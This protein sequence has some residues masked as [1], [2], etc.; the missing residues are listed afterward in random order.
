MLNGDQVDRDCDRR[1]H[2][3][4]EDELHGPSVVGVHSGHLVV[5]ELLDEELTDGG[6]RRTSARKQDDE[7]GGG[8]VASGAQGKVLLGIGGER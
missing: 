6:R 7:R 8:G 1:D 5:G 2:D 4:Q 3:R